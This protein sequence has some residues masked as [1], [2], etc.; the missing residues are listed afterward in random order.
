MMTDMQKAVVEHIH[1]YG[2][3]DVPPEEDGKAAGLAILAKVLTHLTC[4]HGC[5]VSAS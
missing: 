3:T 1:K 5:S 4:L 2:S